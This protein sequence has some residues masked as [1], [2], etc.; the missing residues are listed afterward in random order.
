LYFRRPL[1]LFLGL[2]PALADAKSTRIYNYRSAAGIGPN[3]HSRPDARH[4]YGFRNHLCYRCFV[5]MPMGL[6]CRP[7]VCYDSYS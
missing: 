2:L 1:D 6:D 7:F 5:E 4:E 3:H